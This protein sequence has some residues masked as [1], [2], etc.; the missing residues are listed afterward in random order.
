MD[1]MDFIRRTSVSEFARYLDH[2]LLKPGATYK[3]LEKA[4]EDT[5]RYGFATLVVS[6]FMLKKAAEIA[7]GNIRLATVVG[8]PLGT[9][10]TETKVFEVVRAAEVGAKEIDMV[11]N[12]QAFK[13]RD[14]GIVYKDIAG[15][16]K[17]AKENGI[18]VVKV[19]IETGLLTEEEKIKATQL[20]IEGGADYVKTSTGF[21]AGGAT[22][23][24][25][26]LLY[27]VGSNKIKVKAAGGIRHAIDA[28]AMIIAGASRIGTSTANKII[29]EYITLKQSI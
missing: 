24:D 13:S 17:T 7:G 26:S 1:I 21:I 12:I 9:V 20:V 28:I 25:V 16:V 15:V 22:L 6:P 18:E 29:E 5:R 4:I 23:H 8:F 19:I 11:M 3:D 10:L 27:K 2:T 14:Y